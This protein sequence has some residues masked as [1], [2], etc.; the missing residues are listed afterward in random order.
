MNPA[1]IAHRFAFHAATTDEKRDAHA[2]V[3]QQCRQLADHINAT[4]PNGREKSLA[5]T[6]IEEAMFWGNAALARQE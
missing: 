6:A 3:R 5:I 4:C 2:S 1:D